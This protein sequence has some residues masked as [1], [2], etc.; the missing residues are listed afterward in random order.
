[1][2]AAASPRLPSPPPMAE[3]Q[4]IPTSPGMSL[5]EE[6]SHAPTDS[7]ASRRIRPGSKA[8]DMEGPPLVPLEDIES[9]FPL[10]EHLKAL[11][12]SYTHPSGS[13]QT[14]PLSAAHAEEISQPPPNTSEEIWLY[15]LSRFLVLKTNVIV[16]ALL[17]ATPACSAVTCPE[18]QVSQWQYL[19]AVH[20]P[21]KACA[22]IDYSCHTL[23]W[24]ATVLTS[25]VTFP[26]RLGLG[27]DS[28]TLALQ[29]KELTNVFRR[30]YR[31]YAHA[32]SQHK[33]VFLRVESET[34]IYGFFKQ[35]CETY[36]VI[37]REGYTIPDDFESTGEENDTEK[38]DGEEKVPVEG[39]KKNNRLRVVMRRDGLYAGRSASVSTVIPEEEGEELEGEDLET[40][41]DDVPID[42]KAEDVGNE[43]QG[44][45]ESENVEVFSTDDDETEDKAK[46][47]KREVDEAPKEAKDEKE[48]GDDEKK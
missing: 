18:M 25:S 4:T 44:V 46:E 42:E 15:E 6:P 37:P 39:R 47:A 27:N 21:P 3:D 31:I 28:K 8:I 5:V 12:H 16:V 43:P 22:A 17:T 36:G 13:D 7:N 19:C 38:E 30:L 10:A 20:D 9:A 26:S 1:M 33:E 29:M 41:I 2:A 40:P 34:G 32:W 11:Y 35:V 23:D 14:V 48:G 24:A 45:T